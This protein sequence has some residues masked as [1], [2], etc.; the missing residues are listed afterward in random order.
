[1]APGRDVTRHWLTLGSLG[2]V[3]DVRRTISEAYRVCDET[4]GLLSPSL[5]FDR[6][7]QFNLQHV[8]GC[9]ALFPN[10]S[11]ILYSLSTINRAII[12]YSGTRH[13]LEAGN[14]GTNGC[15]TAVPRQCF[16]GGKGSESV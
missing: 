15:G 7:N 10:Q 5:E 14:V 2:R 13:R 12:W 1:M 8:V 9:G 16:P 11:C 6:Q 4:V 3:D